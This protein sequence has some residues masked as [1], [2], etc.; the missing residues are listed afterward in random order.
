MSYRISTAGMH[1]AAIAQMLAQQT[2][3][4]HTQSQVASGKR[5][6]TPA[7]DPIAAAQILDLD[8]S[9]AQLA[10]FGKNSDAVTNRLNI[11]EQA[12][13][14]AGNLLQRVRELALQA[15]N[16][17]VDDTS[18]LSIATEIKARAQELQD[19]ANRRDAN[20]EYLFSGFS[21]Q[22]QPFSRSAA[23]VSY[24]GDQGVRSLQ[25]GA[26]QRVADSFSGQDAFMN[27]PQGNGTFVVAAGVHNG[28]GSIDAGQV[29]DA[30]AWVRGNY[31]VQFTAP[32]AW[33]VVNA[34]NAVV[35]SGAYTSGG[36]I[37][38][39]GVQVSVSGTPATGDT[40]TIAPAG[41]ES[42]FTTMDKLVANLSAGVSDP[43]SRSQL[44]TN[45]AGS[46]TQLDQILGHVIN[47][48][49]EIGARLSTIDNTTSS[50]QQLDDEFSKSLSK[51]QDLD[52]AEAVTRLNQQQTG[53]QAAQAAYLR[54]GQLSLFSKL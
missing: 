47:Q 44:N 37:A 18:R 27:V 6:L 15:N 35:A 36:T 25:I 41:T 5:V 12:M 52:Y 29:I 40:F 11:G 31:T 21:T 3:L 32:N 20:G 51:L 24:A 1:A 22:T 28:A 14:D 26:N 46:L 4:S 50:R 45:V 49:A 34:A 30:S 13:A 54:I 9:R 10:Q 19:L 7:D 8:R 53:L 39:N 23:G 42:V 17:T 48:R 38:F 43:I 2:Q 33:Q 16:S